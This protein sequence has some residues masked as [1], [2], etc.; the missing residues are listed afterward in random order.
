MVRLQ[1]TSNDDTTSIYTLSAQSVLFRTRLRS[2]TLCPR[3]TNRQDT[4]RN[5]VK[6]IQSVNKTILCDDLV[7]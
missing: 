6:V 3:Q 1:L 2:S 5:E 7:I 4:G